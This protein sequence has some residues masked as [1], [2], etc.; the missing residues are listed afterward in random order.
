MPPPAD[1]EVGYPAGG[2]DDAAPVKRH[3]HTK[4]WESARA[5]KRG[6]M[7]QIRAAVKMSNL[8]K[9]L[10]GIF[11]FKFRIFLIREARGSYGG[12][13][14]DPAF[15]EIVESKSGA[16]VGRRVVA[17]FYRPFSSDQNL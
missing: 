5:G 11:G 2:R 13:R 14:A 15:S 16:A 3:G 10:T 17:L 12:T 8:N 7:R 6:E 9:R 4:T 1:F